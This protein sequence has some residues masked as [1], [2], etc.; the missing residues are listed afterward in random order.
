MWPAGFPGCDPHGA[1]F[2]GLVL[3]SRLFCYLLEIHDHFQPRSPVLSFCSGP[4]RLS[5]HS[6]CLGTAGRLDPL[7][8]PQVGSVWEVPGDPLSSLHFVLFSDTSW[9]FCNSHHPKEK[10]VGMNPVQSLSF[11]ILPNNRGRISDISGNPREEET[12]H[13]EEAV[14]YPPPGCPLQMWPWPRGSP[15]SRAK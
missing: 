3:D 10:P 11:P 1:L 4:C 5:S 7:P 2:L 8:A 6:W 9:C 12:C 13:W 14:C 15:G